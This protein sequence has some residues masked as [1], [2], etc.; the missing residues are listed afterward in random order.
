MIN[1]T[2]SPE[3]VATSPYHFA[4]TLLKIMDNEDKIVPLIHNPIQRHYLANRT[5]RDLILKSRQEGV[6][7]CIQGEMYRYAVTRPT[8]IITLMDKGMNTDNMRNMAER[9]HDNFPDVVRLEDGRAIYKTQRRQDNSITT[10]YEN[11]S[12]V[13]MATAGSVDTGR[14]ASFRKVHGSEVAYWIDAQK[15]VTGALQAGS[16]DWIALESTGN[17]ASGW[18][19]ERCM[20]ALEKPDK[21]IW[22]LHFY[23]WFF[24]DKNQTPLLPGEKLDYDDAEAALIEKY[25]SQITDAKLKWRREKLAE[26]GEIDDFNKEYPSDP[27]VAFKRSGHGYFGDVDACFKDTPL[28]PTPDKSHYYVAG[29][30][31]GQQSDFTAL[32]IMDCNTKQMVHLVHVNKRTWREM[33]LMVRDACEKWGVSLIIAEK[34]SMGSV[35]IEDMRQEFYE[36]G[37]TT[38]IIAFDMTPASKPPLMATY[39]AALHDG[40]LKLQDVFINGFPIVRRDLNSAVSKVT[41]RWGWTVESPRDDQTGHGDTV[42][43]GA[44]MWMAACRM[45]LW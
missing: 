42:V 34:N 5:A 20:E 31:F 15:I 25:K 10:S 41:P 6:S 18:F 37:L 43:A 14:S 4:R 32:M 19:F 3:Q 33:R 27:Y 28:N 29:L 35:N 21:S 40:G 44:L 30:D 11:G 38:D 12:I 22:K 36:K 2:L 8:R 26:I 1:A 13:V 23:P 39:R 45:G 9:F 7:T 16:P 17:G 24:G